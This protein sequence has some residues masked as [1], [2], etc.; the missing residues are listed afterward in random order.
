MY[1]L[2]YFT[3]V[4]DTVHTQIYTLPHIMW[5]VKRNIRVYVYV[6]I[7]KI[8]MY[9]CVGVNAYLCCIHTS[10]RAH[11]DIESSWSR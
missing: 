8:C 4:V 2:H 3:I 10:I 6:Y 9:V 1:I 7:H 5:K 11:I